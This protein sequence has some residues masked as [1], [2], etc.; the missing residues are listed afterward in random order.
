MRRE[1]L[2]LCAFAVLTTVLVGVMLALSIAT[3]A[4]AST[5]VDLAC[6][7]LDV[8]WIKWSWRAYRKAPR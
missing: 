7:P 4:W 6:L 8:F 5:A 3:R 1:L 2:V